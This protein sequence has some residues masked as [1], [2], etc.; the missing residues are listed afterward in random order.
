MGWKGTKIT[1]KK[2]EADQRVPMHHR[3][4]DSLG[5]C[6]EVPGALQDKG[7]IYLWVENLILGLRT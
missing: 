7:V 1:M 2:N 5:G 3:V 6:Q 4:I